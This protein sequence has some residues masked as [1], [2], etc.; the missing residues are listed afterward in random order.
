MTSV[1]LEVNG[2]AAAGDPA[3]R[4]HLADFLRETL[5][6]TGTHLGCE[7]G[8]CGACTLMVDGRPVRACLTL[9]ATC[10]GADVRT[11]ESFDDDPLM[12]RLRQAFSR[13]HALQC[14]YCTPGMLVTAYDIVRRLP[15]ADEARIRE[16]LSGNLCRCTGYMG[17]VAAIADVAAN[18]PPAARVQPVRRVATAAVAGAPVPASATR[19]AAPIVASS[20]P[21]APIVGGTVLERRIP[22]AVPLDDAWSVLADLRRV[23]ACLPGA[24]IEGQDGATV[25]GAFAI[26]IGP[27]TATFRGQAVV[28]YASDARTG[29]VSG[30]GGDPVSRSTAEGTLAFGVAADGAAA[31]TVTA[32]MTYRLKGPL[33][34]FGRPALIANVVDG[35]LAVFAR[36][37]VAAARGAAPVETA[38]VSGTRLLARALWAS[39]RQTL[40][41]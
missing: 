27:M 24:R 18:D 15:G 7:H 4:T 11:V 40:R 33:T 36:N 1:S 37:L 16:E 10:A 26:A 12:V 20:P 41:P 19:E 28:A 25:H 14:G 31:C 29:T 30:A 13:H 23:A 3:P 38:P 32:T 17:I 6:L 9:A 5:H 34:Q 2:R 35:L 39:L 8:V 22:L 21:G